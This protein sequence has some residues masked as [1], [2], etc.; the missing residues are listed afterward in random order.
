MTTLREV[1]PWAFIEKTAR[2]FKENKITPQPEWALFV[3]TGVSRERPPEQE[4]WWYIRAASIFRKLA[5]SSRPL[6]V[7]RL[8]TYYGSRQRRGR[9]R[10]RFRKA[11]GKII[12]TILQQLRSAGLVQLVEKPRKG[13]V[14]TK[15]G[16]K[17]VN[18]IIR[19][20]VKG[21]GTSKAQG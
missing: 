12:R 6:G 11:S 14:L 19:E 16:W 20:L 4:D 5:L 1:D 13:N 7:E 15:K 3:K 17:L 9:R 8:R 2:Y 21:G 10:E 18:Q